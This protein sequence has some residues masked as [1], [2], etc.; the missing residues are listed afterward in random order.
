MCT[1]GEHIILPLGVLRLREIL[2]FFPL[3]LNLSLVDIY[4]LSNSTADI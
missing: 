4:T 3:Q 2:N 1:V